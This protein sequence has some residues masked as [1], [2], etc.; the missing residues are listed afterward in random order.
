LIKEFLKNEQEILDRTFSEFVYYGV[1][2]AHLIEEIDKK[3]NFTQLMI[4]ISEKMGVQLSD[5][6]GT[7]K[8]WTR[9]IANKAHLKNQILPP[10]SHHDQPH[11][12]G[13]F[14]RES[15]KGKHKWVLSADVNSMYPLLGMVGFN[16]SP[17]TFIPK[18]KLPEELKDIILSKFND[19]DEESR[20][21]ISE[22]LWSKTM[23]LLVKHNL[24]L[25]I[26][27]AVF[28]K[29]KL[30]MIPEMVQ[31]IYSSRKEAK[32]TMFKYEQRK[33]LIE[34]ILNERQSN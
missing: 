12:V 15:E 19:Q 1:I 10:K 14:V 21:N 32:K 31:D 2:D 34:K 6:L 26:N 20:F 18:Y 13:G 7:V 17:E 4:M 3:L 11:V 8:P 33:I 16:M 23:D 27:G 24:S 9:Y 5:A 22:E 29:S 30:G 25:G 28:D